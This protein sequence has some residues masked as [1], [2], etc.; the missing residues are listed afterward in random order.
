MARRPVGVVDSRG[1]ETSKDE[2]HYIYEEEKSDT[3]EYIDEE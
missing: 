1:Q 3:Q 2:N